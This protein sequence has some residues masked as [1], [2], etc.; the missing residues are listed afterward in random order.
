MVRKLIGVKYKPHGRTIE[1]GL[2]CYGVAILYLKSQG[3]ILPDIVNYDVNK[4]DQSDIKILLEQGI[5]HKKLDMPEKN[6]IIELTVCGMPTHIGVYLG[7]GE[8]IH[9]TK[10]GVAVEPLWRWQKRIRGYYRIW[11]P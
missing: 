9:A 2:D 8:F 3:I 10:Y 6:C 5:P 1:D 4:K 11:Q 7:E